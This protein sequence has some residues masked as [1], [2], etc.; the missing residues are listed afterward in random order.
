MSPAWLTLSVE[1]FA[2]G[3]SALTFVTNAGD[4]SGDLYAVEQAGRIRIVTPGT[5]QAGAPFLDVTDRIS[6]GG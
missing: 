4:G 6:S 2:S 3:F 5:T 1:P